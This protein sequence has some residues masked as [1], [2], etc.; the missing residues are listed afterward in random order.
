MLQK[1]CNREDYRS[2]RKRLTRGST[3]ALENRRSLSRKLRGR[4]APWTGSRREETKEGKQ[5]QL[6]QLP[7]SEAAK[8][9][10]TRLKR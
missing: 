5:E 9:G 2:P 1:C 6:G 3:E 4:D 7:Y 8:T 10:N